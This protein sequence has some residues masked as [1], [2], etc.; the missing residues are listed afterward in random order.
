M[1][2]SGENELIPKA[3]EPVLTAFG[4]GQVPARAVARSH[5]ASELKKA[6]F[7]TRTLFTI[8]AVRPIF[9]LCPKKPQWSQANDSTQLVR[10]D[11]ARSLRSP[12]LYPHGLS[13]FGLFP[14]SGVYPDRDGHGHVLQHAGP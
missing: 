13:P 7:H 1:P 4:S 5:A 12:R 8:R 11:H 9:S 10:N 2:A 14:V 6:T 3:D